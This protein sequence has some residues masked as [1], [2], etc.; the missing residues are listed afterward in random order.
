MSNIS[1]KKAALNE[2]VNLVKIV[3]LLASVALLILANTLNITAFTVVVL[4]VAAALIAGFDMILSA[5]NSIAEKD[6]FSYNVVL[7]FVTVVGFAVGCSKEACLLVIMYQLGSVFLDYALFRSRKEIFALI[8]EGDSDAGEAFREIVSNPGSLKSTVLSRTAPIMDMLLK[9]ALIVALLYAV[10]MPLIIADMTYT[11][12]IRRGLMLILAAAPAS[13]LISFPLCAETGLSFS[14]AHGVIVKDTS[15]LEKL[16]AVTA[17]AFDKDEVFSDACP[18]LSSISSPILD[19]GTF[20]AL[21]AYVAYNSELRIAAPILAAYKGTVMP[22][23]IERFQDIPGC[24]MEV[25]IH[26]VP[27]CIMTKDV[28]D[29][30]N[31]AIPEK[32]VREGLTFYMAVANKYAGRLCFKENINPYAH[33]VVSDLKEFGGI[34]TVLLSDD[35]EAAAA[36]FADLIGVDEYHYGCNAEKRAEIIGDIKNSLD[37][38]EKLMYVSAESGEFHS[39]ADIDAR[40]GDDDDADMCMSSVGVFGLPVAYAAA[41]R[42]LSIQ[43][44]NLLAIILLKV[45]LVIL[46]L[47]GSATLW[48]IAFLDMI[49][50]CAAVLNSTRVSDDSLIAQLRKRMGV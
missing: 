15:V 45:V 12:S 37:D 26:G 33:A 43:K 9:A 14:A 47:T 2:S 35:S 24:G 28:F 16:S 29:A 31:I 3:R 36:D 17:A 22:Q 27:L 18:K 23:Y 34:K 48:F 21:A 49:L 42:V 13:A 30:R 25:Y 7:I 39:S 20:K 6:F 50:A 40:V 4:S 41:K 5:A 1:D 38:G 11:M 32:D 10:L 44:T 46:A 8:P 19:N